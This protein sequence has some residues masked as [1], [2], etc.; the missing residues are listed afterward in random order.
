[1]QNTELRRRV[2]PVLDALRTL[3]LRDRAFVQR[4]RKKACPY[5]SWDIVQQDPGTAPGWE[6][7][8]PGD[9][10]GGEEAHFGFR[11]CI[12]AP[13]GS[14]GQHLVCLVSTG[15]TDIW[16]YNNPQFLAYLDGELVCGLDVNH[17][18]FDLAC[19]AADGQQWQL[20]LYAY[21]NT[22]A[23]D[24]F[25]KVETAVRDDEI[26]GLY[27]DLKAPFE[28]M[29]LL[30]EGD[31]NAILIGRYL[32][33]AL[34]L[35]D[36]R[37][38]YSGAFYASAAAARRLMKE[39][40]YE[41]CCAPGPVTVS[42][43]GHTHIDLA[44]LWTLAQ[45][46]EKAIR[47]FAT[48]NYLMDRYPEYKFMASQPQLYDFV[49]RDCPALFEKI[50]ARAAQGRWEPE[51]GTWLEP[52]CMMTGGE[53][54]IRQF[55]HGQEFFGREF[56]SRSR[57]LWLPDAFGFSGALPQIMA[58]CGMDWFM[59]TKLAWNDTN[60]MPHDLTRWR[61]I[62]GTEVLAYFISTKDYD[63]RP[64]RNPRPTFNTTYNGLL[65]P[66]QVMGC[67]QRFQ[68]KE[69]TQDVLQCFGYGDGGGGPTAE[70]LEINR[71]MEK[72]I[73]GAPRTRL[74][75]AA[76]F[77]EELKQRLA[78]A[79]EE[80]PCWHGELYLE[81]HRGVFTSQ[82]RNKR[83]NR[84]AEFANMT[85][86]S[87]AALAE[88]LGTGY[89]YPADVLHRSWELTLLNQFHD[90]LPGSALGEVYELSQQ[91][92]KEV[93]ASDAAVAGQALRAI[94]GCVRTDRPGVLVFNQ[95]G[96]ARDTVVRV[97]CDA[98]AVT[99][100][101]HPL[102]CHAA[103]GTLTFA[104][105]GL[106]AKGWRFYPFAD[107]AA[108]SPCAV[109]ETVPGGGYAVCTRFYRIVIDALGQITSLLDRQAGRELIPAG[110]KANEL[111]LFED[112]PDE[113]DAWNIEKYCRRHRF[114]LDGAASL[115]V[116]ENSPVRCCLHLERAISRSQLAQD[117]VIYPHSRR[118]DFD[119]RIDWQ[120]QH[121]LL[122]AAFPLDICANRAQYDIQFG[123]IARDTHANTSWDEARFEV[124]AHKWADLSEPCYGAALLNNGR[125]GYDIRDGVIRLSLLRGA[126]Y[127]DPRAD[128]GHHHF[129]YAL[130]PHLGDW[131]QGDVIL[132][133]YDLNAPALTVLAGVQP[134]GK[135]PAAYSLFQVD[136]PNLVL[137]TV[138]KAEDG[139]G[140]ILRLY[141]S[142]GARTRAVL[143][144]PEGASAARCTPLEQPVPNAVF[145]AGALPLALHP[146]EIC[147]VRVQ[148]AR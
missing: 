60:C 30:D 118:I 6:P 9:A 107:A 82:A 17:T 50:R 71:R 126:T 95:L 11:G 134:Q 119:T 65:N 78:Q 4:L 59:T 108:P 129:V 148:F 93:L 115:T 142:W 88:V 68:D 35:L 122:K 128:Q 87:F 145:A 141:E 110:Q 120:D 29:R 51:G 25:L 146:F 131:R 53:S 112:R 124:C 58:Q 19:P 34:D 38:P 22:P 90:V 136:V 43:V 117:I 123:S 45:T 113:Y 63:Q 84:E 127:P 36:L 83:A 130:L 2:P 106:P 26:T 103:G 144:L 10:I 75:H 101:T 47:S 73:P 85:A 62:D 18:E 48:V 138:K 41:G 21:C 5:H 139:S 14:A 57:I 89:A 133:G 23:R 56:G 125:C 94:A 54:L 69:L 20:G 15:A 86:E 97:D 24:V 140:L 79:Q 33:K 76:P 116:A 3:A 102:P 27:Y 99:D 39:E 40:F 105:A 28:V 70:M 7:F 74:I 132:Q 49:R 64:D 121:V 61:G 77:F 104:A 72:G 46:R 66:K 109:L 92:Y 100:G 147:T 98:A 55:L 8:A 32:E 52:D 80:L 12:T 31:T 67:W 96:F 37:E 91:Q 1:M 81:Y 16:N 13:A 44:W 135:L 114:A 42:C 111:Q 143:S 137:E